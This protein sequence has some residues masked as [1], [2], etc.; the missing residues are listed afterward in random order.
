MSAPA[1]TAIVIEKMTADDW[2]AVCAIYEEGITTGNATFEQSAPTWE[3]WNVGHLATC[4][5]VAR[6]GNEVLGWAALSPV[7]GRGVYAGVAKNN[8][9]VVVDKTAPK[10]VGVSRQRPGVE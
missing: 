5:L 10:A 2:N 1:V 3:K 7:S 4:R 6:A 8:F 9:L